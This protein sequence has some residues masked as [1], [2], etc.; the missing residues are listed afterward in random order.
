V[1]YSF[2]FWNPFLSFS[3][4]YLLQSIDLSLAAHFVNYSYIYFRA[5]CLPQVNWALIRCVWSAVRCIYRPRAASRLVRGQYRPSGYW[6]LCD[7]SRDLIRDCH[8]TTLHRWQ[9]AYF[10]DCR[11]RDA[12]RNCWFVLLRRITSPRVVGLANLTKTNSTSTERSKM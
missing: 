5:K 2:E 3:R 6:G 11:P 10:A 12:S 4:L 1:K 8:W 9:P 7:W